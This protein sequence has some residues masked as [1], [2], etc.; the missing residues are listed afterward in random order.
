ME[1][2]I[3]VTMTYCPSCYE[4]IM[5]QDEQ[6]SKCDNCGITVFNKDVIKQI[7]IMSEK[8]FIKFSE[9]IIKKATEKIVDAELKDIIKE[10][11]EISRSNNKHLR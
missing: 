8:D 7:T 6:F 4:L 5:Q 9:I 1:K 10:I 11:K 2:Q 3:E